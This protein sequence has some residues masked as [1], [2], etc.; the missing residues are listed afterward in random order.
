MDDYYLVCFQIVKHFL[1]PSSLECFL[2]F[3]LCIFFVMCMCVYGFFFAAVNFSRVHFSFNPRISSQKRGY[4]S[5]PEASA[6]SY[7]FP[8]ET[9][10]SSSYFS[11]RFFFLS[12]HAACP[13]SIWLASKN[14]IK[15]LNYEAWI[16]KVNCPNSGCFSLYNTPLRLPTPLVSQWSKA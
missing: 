2:F 4:P 6:Y 11:H 5:S 10:I 1:R 16:G 15:I 14:I 7:L 3:F 8:G 9:L 13:Y 12:G